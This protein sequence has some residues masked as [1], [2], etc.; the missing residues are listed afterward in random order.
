MCIRTHHRDSER[1][2]CR[3]SCGLLP[4]AVDHRTLAFAFVRSARTGVRPCI[5][6]EVVS[7]RYKIYDSELQNGSLKRC[8]LALPSSR[9]RQ[10]VGRQVEFQKNKRPEKHT[11]DFV[12]SRASGRQTKK[13]KFCSDFRRDIGDTG[14]QPIHQVLST[15]DER[16]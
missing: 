4:F 14:Y 15:S 10:R 12:T 5:R 2:A 13:K 16:G 3:C 11:S 1:S 7:I 6:Q 8:R 9:A